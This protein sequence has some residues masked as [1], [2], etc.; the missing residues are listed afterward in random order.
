M[1]NSTS[2]AAK[3]QSEGLKYMFQAQEQLKEKNYGMARTL[4]LQGVKLLEEAVTFAKAADAGIYKKSLAQAYFEQGDIYTEVGDASQAQVSYQKSVQLGYAPAQSKLTTSTSVSASTPA[5]IKTTV[6]RTHSPLASPP[7]SPAS[8]VSPA[9]PV[10]PFADKLIWPL[11]LPPVFL[12]NPS[13]ETKTFTFDAKAEI[14]DTRELVSLLNAADAKSDHYERL[15]DKALDVVAYFVNDPLK[16]RAAVKEVTALAVVKNEEIRTALLGALVDPIKKRVILNAPLLD[17]LAL[18]IRQLDPKQLDADDLVQILIL[19]Q[20]CLSK[21]HVKGDGKKL[22]H[23]VRALSRLLDAM[24][25]ADLKGISRTKNHE[26]LYDFLNGLTEHSNS[27][28]A[29]QARYA[30]QAL[31][32]VPH[33]ENKLNGILRRLICGS[34]G[35]AD[36][37][38]AVVNIDPAALYTA[39]KQFCEAVKTRGSEE[40]WYDE[41][42]A[43]ELFLESDHMIGYEIF[44][45]N[46]PHRQQGNFVRGVINQM[47]QLVTHHRDLRTRQSALSFLGQ[48]WQVPDAWGNHTHMH[49]DILKMLLYYASHPQEELRRT[50]QTLLKSCQALS[51]AKQLTLLKTTKIPDFD[52]VELPIQKK[53]KKFP[54]RLLDATFDRGRQMASMPL[55]SRTASS[56]VDPL[57]AIAAKL[58]KLRES[59][60]KN[61]AIQ[62]ELALYIPVSGTYR[63]QDTDTFDLEARVQEY[64]KEGPQKVLLLMGKAGGGKSTFNRY[65]ERRLWESY[66]PS[67]PIPLFI[68]LPL[69]EKPETDLIPEHL[70]R[71]GFTDKEIA[72]LKQSNQFV[73]ILDGYDEINKL[74]NLYVGNRLETWKAKVV[75]ACR[76]E[77]LPRDAGDYS[78]YFAPFENG[79]RVAYSFLELNVAPFSDAQIAAYIKKYLELHPTAPWKEVD[80]YLTHIDSIPGLKQLIRTPFLLMIAMDVLPVIVERYA[81]I[82][83]IEERIKIT[84]AKLYDEFILQWFR[85][86]EDKLAAKNALPEDGSDI[87]AD[88]W[89]FAKKLAAEMYKRD[90][91]F[92]EYIPP[93]SNLFGD[94]KP[95]PWEMFFGDNPRIK[96][97]RRACP[98]HKIGPTRYAFMHAS[99]IQYFY[100]KIINDE[101]RKELAEKKALGDTP[102]KAAMTQLTERH[103][104][105][106]PARSASAPA[107]PSS[108][109]E[110][111]A[112]QEMRV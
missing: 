34:A 42:R 33:D 92:I 51:N 28:L 13:A 45:K 105:F 104:V 59:T 112:E 87:K 31:L 39:Y 30:Q 98:W 81:S 10:L 69:A 110:K 77:Y 60:L 22:Y 25:D 36:L 15:Q 89:S 32:R 41:L 23:V 66:K 8:P 68:S 82:Q 80:T 107:V 88:F 62:E 67:D 19:L 106:E 18:M 83:N 72:S 91:S 40:R 4:A 74:T 29:F 64:L 3:R 101:A 93:E 95:G 75:V 44:V 37:K 58:Q 6:A 27:R 9:V 86:E 96:A 35:L 1:G 46:A 97:A 94:Q 109:V 111:E 65:L 78:R 57:Q 50:A 79:E 48:M 54:T 108:T 53:P 14:K 26:P 7:T 43:A 24:V 49:H 38:K 52:R 47:R 100:T 84:G 85:R 99:L 63:P 2:K 17:G 103:A 5:E 21:M 20:A 71:H 12:K 55:L 73:F 70:R 61:K 16:M 56:L 90:M 102:T 11:E 76:T